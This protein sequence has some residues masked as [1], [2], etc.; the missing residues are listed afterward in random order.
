MNRKNK[1]RGRIAV[2]GRWVYGNLVIIRSCKRPVIAEQ[3]GLLFYENEYEV[4]DVGQFTGLLDVD[5]KEIYESDIVVKPGYIWFDNKIPNYRGVVAWVYSQWQVIAH[6][7]NPDKR[8]I[9]HGMNY[10][11][12]DDGFDDG[13]KTNWRIIGNVH[14]NPELIEIKGGV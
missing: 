9:S 11:L 13:D 14:N 8:G 1:F 5:G 7:V 10:G 3:G 6:C 4:N 2:T 12:N